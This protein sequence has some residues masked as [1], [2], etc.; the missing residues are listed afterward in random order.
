MLRLPAWSWRCAVTH[1]EDRNDPLGRRMSRYRPLDAALHGVIVPLPTPSSDSR[2]EILWGAALLV[3]LPGIGWLLNMGHQ[4]TCRIIARNSIRPRSTIRSE[5]Y[6]GAFRAGARTGMRGLSLFSALAVSFAW[7]WESGFWRPVCGSGRLLGFPSRARSRSGSVF[8]GPMGPLD[9]RGIREDA[10][11]LRLLAVAT[12]PSSSAAASTRTLRSRTTF[13]VEWIRPG[14]SRY[15]VGR[16]LD[17]C[18][19]CPSRDGLD[20]PLLV[21]R[22]SNV[23]V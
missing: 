22:F 10:I 14:A 15:C 17:S 19:A 3:L 1:S 8:C 13:L 11:M 20:R 18:R 21:V 12:A 7:R 5:R 2:R 23:R 9:R 6:A 16:L 4:V